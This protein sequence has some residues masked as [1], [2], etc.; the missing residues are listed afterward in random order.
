MKERIIYNTYYEHFEEFKAA[1][2][3]LFA[4]LPTLAEDS[5]LGKELRSQVGD[6]FRPIG[7]PAAN[8]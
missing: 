4:I 6:R 7:A 1:S 2:M 5:E 8:F 3:G